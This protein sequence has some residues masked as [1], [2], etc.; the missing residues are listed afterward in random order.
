MVWKLVPAVLAFSILGTGSASAI[1]FTLDDVLPSV[2]RPDVG[3]VDV[4]FTGTI[5][6]TPGYE[7]ISASISSLYKA[8]GDVL[9]SIGAD[10]TFDLTGVLFTVR[11]LSS[12]ALGVYNL[13]NDLVTPARISFGE[14]QI[15]GGACGSAQSNYGVNV[16]AAPVPEPSALGL[17]L[18]GAGV[19]RFVRRRRSRE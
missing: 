19:L 4:E 12:D 16:V 15:G 14:C 18:C 10:P 17:L 1:T 5:T 13:R 8:D 2:V 6:L 7:L 3:F 11:V 9:D